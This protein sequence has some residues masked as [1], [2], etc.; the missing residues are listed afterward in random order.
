MEI[1]FN[2]I[3]KEVERAL[4]CIDTHNRKFF[5]ETA[6]LHYIKHLQANENAVD[7]FLDLDKLKESANKEK[8]ESESIDSS[9]KDKTQKKQETED[10]PKEKDKAV[11][12]NSLAMGGW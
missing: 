7:L 11:D 4:E 3:N 12:N 1:R 9:K 10:K 5:V 6:V 8:G 2:T